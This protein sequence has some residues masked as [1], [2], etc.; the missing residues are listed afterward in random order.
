MVRRP[1]C[2]TMDVTMSSA[3]ATTAAPSRVPPTVR[4]ASRDTQEPIVGG[5]AAGLARHLALPVLWVRVGFIVPRP[6]GGL[7]V[8]LYAGLWLVLPADSAFEQAAPGSRAPPAAV[9]A[10]AGSGGSTDVGPAV[11]LAALGIGGVLLLEVDPR[12]GRG[13]LGACLGL[14]GVALL[15]RQADEAQRERWLD[16]TGRIDPVRVVLRQRRLGVVR[17]ASAAGLALIVVALVLVS[18]RDGGSLGLARDVAAS[19]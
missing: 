10:R 18:L 14:A 11:V 16:T 9:A 7:G 2:V 17:P 19:R 13:V 4:R 12:R 8:F 15:W 1:R 5:V 6:L 3:S